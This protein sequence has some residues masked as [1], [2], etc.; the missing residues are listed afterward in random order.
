MNKLSIRLPLLLNICLLLPGVTLAQ[1]REQR[2]K[3]ED[4]PPAV[5]QAAREQS[6]G[7]KIE[8]FSKE[9]EKGK[10]TYIAEFLVNGHTK[11]V[12]I[13]VSGKVTAVEEEIAYDALPAAAKVGIE[14]Q[15]GNGK[16]VKVE[17]VTK[18]NS[19][20]AYE[21]HIKRAEKITEIKVS[22]EGKLLSKEE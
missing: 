11:E 3:M 14:K 19:V 13:D 15:A 16:V 12:L 5:Q 4:L 6:K 2:V 17:S 10:T 8:G 21:A 9:I 22:P 7:A 20:I 1:E 18:D